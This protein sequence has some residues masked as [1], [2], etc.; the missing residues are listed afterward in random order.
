MPAGGWY[1]ASGFPQGGVGSLTARERKEAHVKLLIG[2]LGAAL[3]VG[4]ATWSGAGQVNCKQVK[5][6]L[7]TGRSVKD[8]AETMVID[9]D[10][11]KKC[12]E[13]AGSGETKGA[14]MPAG[15][16]AKPGEATK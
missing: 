2:L 3:L 1:R 14:D 6:Y 13:Q 9:E 8:V 4:T 15:G 12:Q 7:D 10:E 5:K 11:V 16:G